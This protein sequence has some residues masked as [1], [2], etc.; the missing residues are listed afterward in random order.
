LSS[1]IHACRR[2]RRRRRRHEPKQKSLSSSS[3]AAASLLSN[4]I[5]LCLGIL[6]DMAFVRSF[7]QLLLPHA[8]LSKNERRR[9]PLTI[10][11]YNG[12]SR[13]RRNPENGRGNDG[14]DDDCLLGQAHMGCHVARANTFKT[15]KGACMERHNQNLSMINV[16]CVGEFS[17]F[18][19]TFEEL[20]GDHFRL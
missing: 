2:R 5:I 12:G 6:R 16:L 18:Y 13:R 11:L 7:V 15:S 8:A 10:P 4:L 19:L 3:A 1:S 14:D 17:S 20:Y 9:T